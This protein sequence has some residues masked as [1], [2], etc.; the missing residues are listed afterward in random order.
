[1]SQDDLW[2]KFFARHYER[3]RGLAKRIFANSGVVS[4]HGV[5]NPLDLDVTSWTTKARMDYYVGAALP[6]GAKAVEAAL[7]NAGLSASQIGLLVVCSCTGYATPGLDILLARDL[8][9]TPDTRRLLIG[10]MGCYAA[11]PGLGAAA[12]YATTH[13]RPAV[14]LCVELTSLHVGPPTRDPDQIVVHALFSDAAAAVVVQPDGPGYDV[15][16]VAAVTDAATA[17]YMRYEITDNGFRMGLS[18]RV[19]DVLAK[20]VTGLVDDLLLQHGLGLSDIDGWAVHPGG[21]KILDVVRDELGLNESALA[22]SRTT[23][24]AHGN[25]SSPTVL[26]ALDT[27]LRSPH[28]PRNVTLLAFGPGLTLYAGLLTAHQ[29]QT[30]TT[31]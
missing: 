22:P 16:D 15:V 3:S 13:N 11:L 31:A 1:M 9:M 4:R 6:L 28:R 7:A 14:L 5:A 19:P 10:H 24:S 29:P 18:P 20:H 21:P 2:E 27:L 25:C 26:L 30:T 12:D 23:L 17:D 8:G